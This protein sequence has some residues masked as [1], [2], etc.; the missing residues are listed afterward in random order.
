MIIYDTTPGAAGPFAPPAD[1]AG[2]EG[3][4]RQWART[5]WATDMGFAQELFILARRRLG[6]TLFSVRVEIHGP[7][8][9]DLLDLCR[10]VLQ[11]ET[12]ATPE[13]KAG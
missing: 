3:D 2:G 1:F 12:Q 9:D 6:K 4:Y 11:A 7:H 8:A 5:R 10:R 13:R